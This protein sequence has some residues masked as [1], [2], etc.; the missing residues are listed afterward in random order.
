MS[1]S[2]FISTIVALALLSIAAET[3]ALT[4]GR[5][6][7]IAL[8][9]RPLELSV[10]VSYEPEESSEGL[11]FEAEVYYGQVRRTGDEVTVFTRPLEQQNAVNVRVVSRSS[12][13]EPVVTVVLQGGCAR[14]TARKYVVFADLATEVVETVAVVSVPVR[15]VGMLSLIHI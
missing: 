6:H 11:C 14:K 10:S 1:T 3:S 4:L 5:A 13:D 15:P 7:A 12:I 8:L 2:N 9:G